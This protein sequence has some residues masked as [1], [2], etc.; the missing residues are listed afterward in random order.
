MIIS[1]LS[2]RAGW[3]VDMSS[4]GAAIGYAYT[5]AA[6]LRYALQE[7]RTGIIVTGILGIV[8]SICFLILL[9]VPIPLF[10]CS[11]GKESYICLLVWIVLGLIF[12]LRSSKK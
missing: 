2:L 6:A 3:I 11:L 12:F 7:K 1:I 4:T 8:L 5:S 9:L 10:N